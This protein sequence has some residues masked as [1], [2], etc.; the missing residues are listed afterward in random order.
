MDGRGGGWRGGEGRG[1]VGYGASTGVETGNFQ[2]KKK[3]LDM[4]EGEV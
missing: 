1:R 4:D 3:S 2:K